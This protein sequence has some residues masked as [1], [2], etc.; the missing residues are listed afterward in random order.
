MNAGLPA[1]GALRLAGLLLRRAARAPRSATSRTADTRPRPIAAASARRNGRTQ[2]RRGPWSR[3]GQPAR[4]LPRPRPAERPSGGHASAAFDF[5]VLLG[6]AFVPPPSILSEPVRMRSVPCRGIPPPFF[7]R[8]GHSSFRR[9][10]GGR[11]PSGAARRHALRRYGYSCTT[12]GLARD[13]R[14]RTIL[15]AKEWH[16]RVAYRHAARAR[17]VLPL[18][19]CLQGFN[20]RPRAGRGVVLASWLG[21]TV[22]SDNRTSS[23]AGQR[24]VTRHMHLSLATRWPRVRPVDQR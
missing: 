9:Y 5:A 17:V 8:H 12:S 14:Q 24:P 23:T 19:L 7:R 22:L 16:C 10:P 21:A 13:A 15:V 20:Y 4:G 1:V 11:Q 6:V 3:P 2:R 18:I